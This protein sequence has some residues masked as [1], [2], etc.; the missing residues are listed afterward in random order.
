MILDRLAA[1][2]LGNK[3]AGKTVIQAGEGTIRLEQGF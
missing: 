3:L 2:L 1:T